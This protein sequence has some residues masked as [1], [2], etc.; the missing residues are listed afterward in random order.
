MEHLILD[1]DP[2][3]RV[4]D[5]NSCRTDG[6]TSTN[7]L[8]F[9]STESLD[10]EFY[11]ILSWL[12]NCILKLSRSHNITHVSTMRFP[13]TSVLS[14]AALLLYSPH[15]EAAPGYCNG[16]SLKRGCQRI[17]LDGFFQYTFAARIPVCIT[18][19]YQDR[20]HLIR[21]THLGAHSQKTA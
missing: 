4:T 8:N 15:V 21:S 9:M 17:G 5:T 7:H 3:Y 6:N 12:S 16:E 19:R 2:K 10:R 11:Y 13:F 20:A 18:P 14:L 1:T